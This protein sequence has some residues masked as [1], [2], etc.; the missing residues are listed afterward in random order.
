MHT[1]RP[2]FL[3]MDCA[4]R[5]FVSDNDPTKSHVIIMDITNGATAG[6]VNYTFNRPTGIAFDMFNNLFV[7]DSL[8][9]NIVR[10]S[11]STTSSIGTSSGTQTILTSAIIPVNTAFALSGILTVLGDLTILGQISMAPNSSFIISGV[12]YIG[13]G[14][15]LTLSLGSANIVRNQKR[16]AIFPV[17][18]YSSVSGKFEAV[19][20]IPL[21]SSSNCEL[22]AFANYGNTALSVIV[23]PKSKCESGGLSQGAI[24]GIAIGAVSDFLLLL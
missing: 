17:A 18:Q 20:V 16:S 10:F 24:I 14:V 8:N 1:K 15:N 13:N 23:T 6:I 9:G 3:A 19:T 2:Q 21:M 22:E 5:F 4:D 12:L 11:C 7:V